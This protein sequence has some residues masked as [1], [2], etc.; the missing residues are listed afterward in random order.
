MY[1]YYLS[2]QED[3]DIIIIKIP[4]HRKIDFDDGDVFM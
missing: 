2:S 1:V 4:H 3:F